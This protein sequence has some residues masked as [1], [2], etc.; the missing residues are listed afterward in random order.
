VKEILH[1]QALV[2]GSTPY[3]ERDSIVSLFSLEKGRL[4]VYIRNTKKSV[5]E[6]G[7]LTS[8]LTIGNFTLNPSRTDLYRF[9]EGKAIE[10]H[11]PL[12]EDYTLLTTALECLKVLK[13]SQ[14]RGSPAPHLYLLLCRL[15]QHLPNFKTPE[16]AIP[17]LQ[18]KLLK[19]EGLISGNA[20]CPVCKSPATH[21]FDGEFYC[22]KHASPYSQQWEQKAIEELLRL[23]HCRSF[24][25]IEEYKLLD[26]SRE[27]IGELFSSLL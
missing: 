11:L 12:R 24:Q 20:A 18:T 16:L 4:S 27:Q 17:L 10:L 15:L 21:Y 8:P 7:A 25:E 22:T 6:N 2:L 19:H 1:T 23:F 9:V 26:S 14:W 5:L 3:K 13:E